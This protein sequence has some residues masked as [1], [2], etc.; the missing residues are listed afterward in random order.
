M[1]ITGIFGCLHCCPNLL[2]M[3]DDSFELFPKMEGFSLMNETIPG[4]CECLD[5]LRRDSLHFLEIRL[6]IVIEHNLQHTP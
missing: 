6:H 2:E 5:I 1:L 3:L 4:F